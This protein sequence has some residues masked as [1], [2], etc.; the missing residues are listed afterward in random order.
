MRIKVKKRHQL[1][2]FRPSSFKSHE[3]NLN[4]QNAKTQGSVQFAPVYE[5][6]KGKKKNDPGEHSGKV[7]SIKA[8]KKHPLR[9]HLRAIS[10]IIGGGRETLSQVTLL[11]KQLQYPWSSICLLFY[12]KDL[13]S[14]L[15]QASPTLP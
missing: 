5:V 15:L 4:Q 12:W 3:K 10:F 11:R 13:S 14:V 1:L 7:R 2:F 6:R 9:I 8:E